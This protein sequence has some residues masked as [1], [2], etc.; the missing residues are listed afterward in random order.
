MFFQVTSFSVHVFL[1]ASLRC[2]SNKYE[3]CFFVSARRMYSSLMIPFEK[4]TM[5][6]LSIIPY[7]FFLCFI[8]FIVPRFY[9]AMLID[10]RLFFFIQN[11]QFFNAH[12]EKKIA[13]LFQNC[14]SN[15]I[16]TRVPYSF[17]FNR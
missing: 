8:F 7:V 14:A 5:I 4:S 12:R 9:I 13:F 6:I 2:G 11:A 3:F 15:N 10:C 16:R 17:F 1:T